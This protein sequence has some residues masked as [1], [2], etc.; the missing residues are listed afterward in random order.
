[1]A[2]AWEQLLLKSSLPS[3][4]AWEHL[5][6]AGGSGGT[7][8][9]VDGLEVKMDNTCIEAVVDMDDIEVTVDDNNIEVEIDLDDIKVEICQTS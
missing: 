3:G 4:T 5:I 7:L 8:W 1:M 2:T 6:S 9:L